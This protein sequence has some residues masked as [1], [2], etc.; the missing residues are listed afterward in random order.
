MKKILSLVLLLSVL[1]GCAAVLSSCGKEPVCE[2]PNMTYTPVNA[3]NH[4]GTCPDCGYTTTPA[5][6]CEHND[7]TLCGYK[8]EAAATDPWQ[9]EFDGKEYPWE[10]TNLVM[11]VG[12]NSNYG[13]LEAG[14]KAFVSGEW[15]TGNINT[16]NTIASVDNGILT[17]IITRNATAASATHVTVSYTY[18]SDYV[19]GE[20]MP[21]I[22]TEAAAANTPDIYYNFIYDMVGASINGYFKNVKGNSYLGCYYE[23]YDAEKDDR[24]YNWE[25]MN[26]LTFSPNIL[27]LIAS[28]YSGDLSRADL[29]LPV[30][31]TLLYQASNVTGDVDGNGFVNI[32]DFYAMINNG[33][34]TWSKIIEYTEAVKKPGANGGYSLSGTSTI[35]F[36]L[37]SMSGLCS[38][39]AL[40]SSSMQVVN[41]TV[42]DNGEYVYSYP[43]KCPTS[44]SEACNTF[45]ELFGNNDGNRDQS[46]TESGTSGILICK[47]KLDDIQTV[48]AQTRIL[49]GSPAALGAIEKSMYQSMWNEDEGSNGFAV[50]PIAK[51]TK[52]SDYQ[53]T[54]HNIGKV[55]AISSK[56]ENADAACAYINHNTVNSSDILE[57]YYEWVLGYSRSVTEKNVEL[58]LA[59][60]DRLVY[61]HDKVVEDAIGILYNLDQVDDPFGSGATIPFGNTRWH[62]FLLSW[63]DGGRIDQLYNGVKDLKMARLQEIQKTFI[64]NA[65]K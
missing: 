32:N 10:T 34:W 65:A 46:M 58:L 12:D 64:A 21:Q 42:G 39:A 9:D 50:A 13:E 30:S 59:M 40:Y 45:A 7:C 37:S 38:T 28:D 57:E 14:G 35:G 52:E 33:D 24:G 16:G 19:W 3:K 26:D 60:R 15:T 23:T 53:T 1:I 18:M 11:S 43:N 25:Y 27:Y 31:L 55:F 6:K 49:V 56:C 20:V 61:S 36:A 8:R 47:T 41:R 54:I 44:L 22:A 63:W 4:K 2:H 29:I 62:T 5:H 17:Q 51:L 48:F